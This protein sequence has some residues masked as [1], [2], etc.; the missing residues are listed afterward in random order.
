M[1]S[2]Q[3]RVTRRTALALGAAGLVSGAG[4]VVGGTSRRADADPAAAD[5]SA[6]APTVGLQ[7]TYTPTPGYS[8]GWSVVPTPDGGYAIAGYTTS[9]ATVEGFAAYLLKVDADGNS[10]W[11]REYDLL[12]DDADTEWSEAGAEFFVSLARADGGY[13]LAGPQFGGPEQRAWLLKTAAD[14]TP[15]WTRTYGGSDGY[16]LAYGMTP[17]P[18]GGYILVGDW[19]TP[20]PDW[21]P[22]G[23]WFLR[24][25]ADGD[26]VAE[27][28]YGECEGVEG[29]AFDVV[30]FCDGYALTGQFSDGTDR[31]AGALRVDA[32]GGVRWSNVLASDAVAFAGA[33]DGDGGLYVASSTVFTPSTSTVT[34]ARLDAAGAVAASHALGT[35]IAYDALADAAGAVLVGS[36]ED[37]TTRGFASAVSLDGAERWRLS[38]DPV[39]VR[40]VAR[41]TGGYV[42]VGDPPDQAIGDGPL[43]ARIDA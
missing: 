19:H 11:V 6:P 24:T 38:F 17:A 39:V 5:S 8:A 41:T 1:D 4:T 16:R 29:T 20:A 28:T 10:E 42:L 21:T 27:R 9:G 40:G 34:L 32:D 23:V 37:P 14:G 13:A 12:G 15:E 43:L 26:P 25:D 18:D 33:S 35:G 22:S 2:R 31:G 3:S 7:Q 30:P 36:N